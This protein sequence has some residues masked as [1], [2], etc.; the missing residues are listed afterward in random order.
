MAHG[1]HCIFQD[2]GASLSSGWLY[3]NISVGERLGFGPL[4]EQKAWV[5]LLPLLITKFYYSEPVT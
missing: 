3:F 2:D 4:A 1:T 5:Q